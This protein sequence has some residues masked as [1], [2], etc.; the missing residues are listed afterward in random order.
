M[1]V[2]LGLSQ[3][4]IWLEW[5]QIIT[6]KNP[7]DWISGGSHLIIDYIKLYL[8]Y[9]N[10]S[11]TP[12]PNPN[13]Y[14]CLCCW[15][16]NHLLL[17]WT[18]AHSPHCILP[19]HDDFLQCPWFSNLGGKWQAKDLLCCVLLHKVCIPLIMRSPLM[20]FFKM[21]KDPSEVRL[22]KQSFKWSAEHHIIYQ[23]TCVEPY[24]PPL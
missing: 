14:A 19:H 16:F 7:K 11:P 5:S 2:I 18:H 1:T 4:F 3:Q 9:E 23:T 22:T 20:K 13:N 21:I 12:N 10:S 15:Y 6:E 24:T 8:C 17:S